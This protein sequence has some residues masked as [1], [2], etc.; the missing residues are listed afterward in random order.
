MFE[1]GSTLRG[2][3]GLSLRLVVAPR[4]AP[5]GS[6]LLDRRAGATERHRWFP[7]EAVVVPERANSGSPADMILDHALLPRLVLVRER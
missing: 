2:R 6:I 7:R 1:Q 5:T 3:R 4:I